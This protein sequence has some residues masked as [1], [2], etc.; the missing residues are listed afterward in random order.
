MVMV[1]EGQTSWGEQPRPGV[2]GS[3]APSPGV[4]LLE[5]GTLALQFFALSVQAGWE[6]I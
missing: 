3:W 2:Q 4:S 5:L 1:G 6:K